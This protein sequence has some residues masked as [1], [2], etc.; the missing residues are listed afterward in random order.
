M[1][2]LQI[3]NRLST[4]L[5]IDLGTA[6]T[7]VAARGR[8]IL[9]SE[10][11]VVAVSDEGASRK[12]R[13]VGWEAKE[14]L[15]RTPGD[16]LAIRPL[17]DGVIA[18]FE[19]TEAMLRYFIARAQDGPRLMRPRVLVAV[20]SGITQV[21]RRAVREAALSAGARVVQLIEEPMAAAIGAGLPVTAPFGNMVV[22]IG[23]G[24][25]EVAVISLAGVVYAH[26]L[27][28]GGDEMD[29]AIVT[30]VKRKH[31]LLIGQR[32]A[33]QIKIEIGNALPV[34][35]MQSMEVK[36]RDP[37]AGV[38]RIAE[39]KS[40]EVREALADP[41]EK[42]IESVRRALEETPPELSSDIVDAGVVLVGG[43]A[44]LRGLDGLL[45]LATGLPVRVSESPL[46]AVAVGSASCLEDAELLQRVAID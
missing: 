46:T 33:E 15:G 38:P 23:G 14:M 26:S 43:G 8:G 10:P 24:T 40:E 16:L 21:E 22:D 3:L 25:T 5:A 13:A 27:R 4:D 6:N 45:S 20:P 19:L 29:E 11:S 44:L 41:L 30:H 12:L 34:D 35:D 9:F 32:M 17:K 39:L 7:V 1:P 31:N 18:D 37:I 36:G 28:V 42:V 2:L